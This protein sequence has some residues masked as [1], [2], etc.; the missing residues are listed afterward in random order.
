MPALSVLSPYPDILIGGRRGTLSMTP[1]QYDRLQQAHPHLKLPPVDNL[2]W[3][4][5]F[6]DMPY[7]H[8]PGLCHL[9]EAQLIGRRTLWIMTAEPGWEELPME[10]NEQGIARVVP[11]L[12]PP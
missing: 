10:L 6:G 2:A 8:G 3:A 1:G 5:K 12:S 7:P 4:F 9:T 11:N